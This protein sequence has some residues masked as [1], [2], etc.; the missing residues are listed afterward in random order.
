MS[1]I[2]ERVDRGAALLD[3]KRPGWWRHIDLDRLDIASACDC[4][5]GQLGDGFYLGFVVDEL[6]LHG[7]DDEALYGLTRESPGLGG[8]EYG[9]LTAA[10]RD[11]ICKRRE[12]A[13]VSQ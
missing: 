5:V 2:T 11:L 4:V 12:D 10:W 6:D 3:E 7:T 8:K 13:G 1:G 9:I